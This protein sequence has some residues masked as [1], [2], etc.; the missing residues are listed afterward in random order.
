MK[1]LSCF[2]IF[3]DA[4]GIL[5]YYYEVCKSYNV[6]IACY[7][8]CLNIME[9]SEWDVKNVSKY[10]NETRLF[11]MLKSDSNDTNILMKYNREFFIKQVLSDF[12]EGIYLFEAD[13]EYTGNSNENSDLSIFKQLCSEIVIGCS[14]LSKSGIMIIKVIGCRNLP[15]ISLLHLL[16]SMFDEISIVKPHSSRPARYI[17]FNIYYYYK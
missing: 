2:H 9:N 3:T 7:G 6:P 13:G 5:N 15:F 8:L 1:G 4:G 12:P 14:I 10:L 17:I 16:S 11:K